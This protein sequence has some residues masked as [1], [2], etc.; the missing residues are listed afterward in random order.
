MLWTWLWTAGYWVPSKKGILSAAIIFKGSILNLSMKLFG[1]FKAHFL[2]LLF[3]Q[4][5]PPTGWIFNFQC[6]FLLFQSMIS[7]STAPKVYQMPLHLK[8]PSWL[9][10][11]SL[12]QISTRRFSKVIVMLSL[13]SGVGISI[14]AGFNFKY[15]LFYFARGIWKSAQ[16]KEMLKSTYLFYFR[17]WTRLIFKV[18]QMCLR[19]C[20][21]QFLNN[22]LAVFVFS[23]W[24]ARYART[25]L[26]SHAEDS[27][28][29]S[30]RWEG[31]STSPGTKKNSGSAAISGSGDFPHNSSNLSLSGV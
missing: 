5:N 19:V 30:W 13:N 29:L 24:G 27:G 12:V 31:T 3:F 26:A 16:N 11:L 2:A 7:I 20:D 18:K 8:P 21:F 9:A 23:Q 4:L 22:F 25:G 15:R 17:E 1:F 6:H 10:V 14:Q 28:Q